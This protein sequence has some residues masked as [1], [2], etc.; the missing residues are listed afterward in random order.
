MGGQALPDRFAV[1]MNSFNQTRGQIFENPSPSSARLDLSKRV[2]P[3]SKRHTQNL[4]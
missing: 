2:I 1:L 4:A 3:K